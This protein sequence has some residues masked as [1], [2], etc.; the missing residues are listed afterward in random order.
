AQFDFYS[1]GGLDVACLGM[2]ELDRDGH[3]NVSRL[4]P[5]VVGPGGFIDITQNAGKVVF[6]GSFEAKGSIVDITDKGLKVKEHG[7]IQKLVDQVA[8]ISFSATYAREH[9]RIVLYVTERAVFRLVDGGLRMEETAPGVD[10]RRDVLDRMAF[11]PIV[12]EDLQTMPAE[13]F[14]P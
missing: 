1:G 6:C 9:G 12:A 4:G 7:Q 13:C 10:P 14:Q 11:Q 5:D 3:V 8:E 2:A